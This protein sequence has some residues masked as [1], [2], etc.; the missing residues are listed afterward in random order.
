MAYLYKIA[1]VAFYNVSSFDATPKITHENEELTYV[2]E[3]AIALGNS[4]EFPA[5]FLTM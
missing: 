5:L 4:S 1:M 3:K 2:S